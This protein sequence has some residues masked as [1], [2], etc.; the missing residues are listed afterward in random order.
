MRCGPVFPVGKLLVQFVGKLLVCGRG[1]A[2]LARPVVAGLLR[3]LGLKIVARLLRVDGV[4]AFVTGAVV[5]ALAQGVD[6]HLSEVTSSS[7]P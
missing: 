4:I 2:L 3:V 1:A 6:A 5:F 7:P